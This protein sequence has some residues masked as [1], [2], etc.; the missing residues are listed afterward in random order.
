MHVLLSCSVVTQHNSREHGSSGSEWWCLGLLRIW[1]VALC[2][3][4][5]K[6]RPRWGQSPALSCSDDRILVW[7]CQNK[8]LQG[9]YDLRGPE[10]DTCLGM[11]SVNILAEIYCKLL[12]Q[13]QWTSS[14]WRYPSHSLAKESPRCWFYFS[15][16]SEK[17]IFSKWTLRIRHK[18]YRTVKWGRLS[19]TVLK[20]VAQTSWK[21]GVSSTSTPQSWRQHSSLI[22]KGT[23]ERTSIVQVQCSLAN[24][25]HLGIKFRNP[26][27][28][29]SRQH[30]SVTGKDLNDR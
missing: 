27:S 7:A 17:C 22:H 5:R 13:F 12:F 29:D 18:M 28:V 2:G 23:Q 26:E 25:F 3:G 15:F 30:P 19:T 24:Y 8:D 9:V 21:S 4:W 14:H 1:E 10:G 6:S 20:T 16:S 11:Q